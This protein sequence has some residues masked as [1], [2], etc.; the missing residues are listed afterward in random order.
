MY[1]LECVGFTSLLDFI[2]ALDLFENL[3][4]EPL[5][6]NLDACVT[7]NLIQLLKG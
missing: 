5:K 1:T 7:G 6:Q 3:K 2:E 4:Y